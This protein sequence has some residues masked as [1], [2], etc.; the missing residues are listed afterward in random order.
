MRSREVTLR[1]GGDD[2]ALELKKELGHRLAKTGVVVDEARG[3]RIS[4]TRRRS[5]RRCCAASRP[6]P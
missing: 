1:G 5:H 2:V 4:R 6:K 3:S